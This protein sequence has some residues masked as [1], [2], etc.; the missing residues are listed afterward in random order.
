MFTDAQQREIERLIE[1]MMKRP[2]YLE[3]RNLLQYTLDT[4]T[5]TFSVTGT[6]LDEDYDGRPVAC[7]YELFD[8]TFATAG[9][10]EQMCSAM[11]AMLA[12]SDMLAALRA[13]YDE[14]LTADTHRYVVN[15]IAAATLSAAEREQLHELERIRS[16]ALRGIT[17]ELDELPL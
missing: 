8:V 13:V 16:L 5:D 10:H 12:A 17:G 2:C 7:E 9:G 14:G 11:D 3:Q 4:T 6:D 15:A 1:V